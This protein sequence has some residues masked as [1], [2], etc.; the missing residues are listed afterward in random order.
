MTSF[1]THYDGNKRVRQV[2]VV[3]KGHGEKLFP[4]DRRLEKVEDRKNP[5]WDDPVIVTIL[6]CYLSFHYCLYI[7]VSRQVYLSLLILVLRQV[8]VYILL[9]L[10]RHV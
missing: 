3:L 2:S 10:T 4:N 6:L 8:I 1:A 5:G 7:Y 9:V